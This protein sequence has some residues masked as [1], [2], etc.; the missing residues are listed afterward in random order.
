[1]HHTNI[2]SVGSKSTNTLIEGQRVRYTIGVGR[3]G[4]EAMTVTPA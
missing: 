3:R 4:P 2:T 1:V